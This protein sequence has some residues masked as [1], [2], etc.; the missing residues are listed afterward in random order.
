M[1]EGA[2]ALRVPHGGPLDCESP[3][4]LQR[5]RTGGGAADEFRLIPLNKRATAQSRRH[6]SLLQASLLA[7]LSA[8]L[9]Y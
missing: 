7:C 8:S 4:C 3:H 5:P 6:A 9:H 1:P 2:D